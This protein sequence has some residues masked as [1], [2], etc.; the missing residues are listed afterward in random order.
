MA[1]LLAHCRQLAVAQADP[2]NNWKSVDRDPTGN[3]SMMPVDELPN[4]QAVISFPLS[5]IVREI[6]KF[7]TSC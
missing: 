6:L 4:D 5:S 1:L 7:P 3:P 2:F